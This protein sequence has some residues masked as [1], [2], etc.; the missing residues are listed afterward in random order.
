MIIKYYHSIH[1]LQTPQTFHEVPEFML[2]TGK[3]S[4]YIQAFL[5]S[6]VHGL[7]CRTFRKTFGKIII[8]NP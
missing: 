4:V 3:W 1:Y 6:Y 7:F 5:N 2:S 8:K